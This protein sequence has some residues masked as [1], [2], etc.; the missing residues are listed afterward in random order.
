MDAGNAI[1][2]RIARDLVGIRDASDASDA[3]DGD[4]ASD[5]RELNVLNKS[6]YI[7]KKNS[8]LV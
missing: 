7:V 5:V 3:S 1:D 4:T 6:L 8:T 2:A